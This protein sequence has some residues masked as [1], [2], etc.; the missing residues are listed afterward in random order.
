MGDDSGM[1]HKEG[2]CELVASG[3]GYGQWR[4]LVNTVANFGFHN[5]RGIY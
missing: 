2:G 5:R 3:S 1:D 4:A